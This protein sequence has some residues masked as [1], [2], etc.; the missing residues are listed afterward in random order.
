MAEFKILF[1]GWLP[2]QLQHLGSFLLKD[3][4]NLEILRHCISADLLRVCYLGYVHIHEEGT[5]LRS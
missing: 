3:S 4:P 1:L 2:N 5:K